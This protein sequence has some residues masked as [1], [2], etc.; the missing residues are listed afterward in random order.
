[1]AALTSCCR[2]RCPAADAFLQP[3]RVAPQAVAAA[4]PSLSVPTLRLR[5]R[6][7]AVGFG[8]EQQEQGSSE[9][10]SRGTGSQPRE[11]RGS[12]GGR[13]GKQQRGPVRQ[14]GSKPTSER[15][16]LNKVCRVFRDW[17]ALGRLPGWMLH[18]ETACGRKAL[19]GACATSNATCLQASSHCRHDCHVPAP[20][21]RVQAIAAAGVASRRGADEL[22]LEGKV[23]VNERT[24]TELGTQVDLRKDKVG[25]LCVCVCVGGGGG[26]GAARVRRLRHACAG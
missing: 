15:Q 17:N 3:P 21:W 13:P 22:I 24:V 18:G 8:S 23:K 26:E 5:V 19:P 6:A 16:R 1:M 4:P 7:Q 2:G 12:S 25:G 9:R 20:P 11:R 10:R 14:P